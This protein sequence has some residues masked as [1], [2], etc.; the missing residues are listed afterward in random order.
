M[1]SNK[2]RTEQKINTDKQKVGSTKQN[3]TEAKF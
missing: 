1:T 3:A 2:E